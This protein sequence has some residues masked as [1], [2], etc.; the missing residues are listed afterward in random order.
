[1]SSELEKNRVAFNFDYLSY[2]KTGKFLIL[3]AITI[4]S[5]CTVGFRYTKSSFY[6]LASTYSTVYCIRTGPRFSN[7]DLRYPDYNFV[8]DSDSN[9]SQGINV[10]VPQDPMPNSAK[11]RETG[12]G[13]GVEASS[14]K[15]LSSIIWISYSPFPLSTLLSTHHQCNDPLER[16]GQFSFPSLSLSLSTQFSPVGV[17]GELWEEEGERERDRL[18]HFQTAKWGEGR[19]GERSGGNSAPPRTKGGGA[20]HSNYLIT[21]SPLPQWSGEIGLS[22]CLWKLVAMFFL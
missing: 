12:G 1:M 4:W 20:E 9:I 5:L 6:I 21:A 11:S 18:T 17:V 13:R 8:R 3:L 10:W 15:R 14:R 2:L 19:E 16:G 22:Y 7:K